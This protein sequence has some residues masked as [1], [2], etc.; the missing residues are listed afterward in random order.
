[1]EITVGKNLLNIRSEFNLKQHEISGDDISRNLISMIENDKTPLFE[2]VAKVL[3]RNITEE[4]KHKHPKVFIDPEDLLNPKR[5]EAKKEA[6]LYVEKIR[7]AVEKKKELEPSFIEKID[8]FLAKWNML[9]KS[10][11]IYD[12]MGDLY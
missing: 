9:D 2:N 5:Y 12:L 6:D 7:A 11:I 10:I 8:K 1:M 3:A 4:I